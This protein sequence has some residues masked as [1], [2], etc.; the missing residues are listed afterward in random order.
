[1]GLE[2]TLATIV[3]LSV[4]LAKAASQ[5]E[6][7]GVRRTASPQPS[8]RLALEGSGCGAR[9]VS[10]VAVRWESQPFPARAC[11]CVC[12]YVC[13]C[14]CV[15][16]CVCVRVLKLFSSSP[17]GDTD[18]STSGCINGEYTSCVGV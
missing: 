12:V 6:L 2:R 8:W 7:H 13:V 16:V 4:V 1:M 18:N 15:C 5:G 14:T 10:A 3:A 9:A 11:T 17:A